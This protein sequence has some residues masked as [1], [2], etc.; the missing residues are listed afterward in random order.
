MSKLH[1][2]IVHQFGYNDPDIDCLFEHKILGVYPNRETAENHR[3]KLLSKRGF[4]P[5]LAVTKHAVRGEF[6]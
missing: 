4:K 2:Y 3:T 1:V 5:Y 6:K